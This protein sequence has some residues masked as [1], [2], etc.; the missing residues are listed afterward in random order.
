[1]AERWQTSVEKGAA[2]VKTSMSL[3]E[4]GYDLGINDGQR[5][6]TLSGQVFVLASVSHPTC[7]CIWLYRKGKSP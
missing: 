7:L 6:V 3:G 5:S 2:S 1:M 4:T